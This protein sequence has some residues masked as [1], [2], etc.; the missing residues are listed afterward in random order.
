MSS[1]PKPLAEVEL[2]KD[3]SNY[4]RGSIAAGLKDPVTGAIASSDTNLVK[5]HGM[6]MQD[7]RD[8]RLERQKQKLEPLHS[9]M[10][11]VRLPGGVCTPQQWLQL[12][13]IARQYAN[14][15]L[16]LTTRQ[17]FQFHGVFK[18][19]LKRTI[20]EINR[21]L[22]NTIAACGDVNRNVLSDT[23]PHLSHLHREVHDWARKISDHLLPR[24]RAYHEIWID[25]ELVAG[26]EAK[27]DVEPLY[28]KHYLPRKFKTAL[29]IPPSNEVDVFAN[30]LGFIAIVENGR[31]QGFNVLAGGGMGMTHGEKATY[32]RLADVLGFV[33]PELTLEAA[34]AVLTTQRDHGDRT[35]RKHAR[36]KY[37]IDDKGVDWFRAEVSRRMSRPLEPARPFRFE[38]TGDRY[39]WVQGENGLWHYTAYIQNGRIQDLPGRLQLTGLRKIAEIHDGEFRCTANQN[40]IIA[41]VRPANLH[42]VA[43]LLAQHQLDAPSRLSALRLNAMACVALPT[44]ALAMAESERYLPSLIDKIEKV[45]DAAGLRQ[46]PITLRMTGCPNGCARPF[47]AEIG[48]VGK[49]L[50]K[51][52]LYLG[53]DYNGERMNKLYREN[54][55]EE[56][57]LAA[58]EPL[59]LRYA[60]DRQPDE[61]FGNFL[62]RVG[63]VKA[64]VQGRDFHD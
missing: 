2:I 36:L 27:E 3:A 52:N 28:G 31:L 37:T 40:V 19:N 8:L 47:L 60:A 63:E 1:P 25:D 15:T 62:V 61:R 4:L 12:D 35:N 18:R 11:R 24:T 20:Q 16:R 50:G 55:G 17:T 7:D 44:C 22:L 26:G 34:T 29:A 58:L 9:F 49:N 59:L 54:V 10:I 56:E 41:N 30:D 13:A 32:P 5:F 21:A 39:G 51:Y 48:L 42:R 33:P 53:A 6:Y 38:S 45:I 43:A 14:G 64:T 23:N 57:I 46:E